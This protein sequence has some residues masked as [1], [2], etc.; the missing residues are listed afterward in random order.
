MSHRRDEEGI[1]FLVDSTGQSN[2]RREASM[3]V[4]RWRTDEARL[5]PHDGEDPVDYLP[6]LR[7]SAAPNPGLR[8]DGARYG[9]GG[10]AAGLAR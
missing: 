10:V 4:P 2:A 1:S 5:E 8:G 6:R 3:A 9:C 7:G